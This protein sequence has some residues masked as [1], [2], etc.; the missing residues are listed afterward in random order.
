MNTPAPK[1]IEVEA[2]RGFRACGRT[3]ERGQR[4][5]LPRD[6]ALAVIETGRGRAA[7]ADALHVRAVARVEWREVEPSG[8][9]RSSRWSV[10]GAK[11]EGA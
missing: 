11:S 2:V 5:T 3:V 8:D 1:E 10:T 7:G 6:A 4:V 9:R